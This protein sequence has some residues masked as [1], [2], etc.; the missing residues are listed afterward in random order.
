MTLKNMNRNN[1]MM[2]MASVE[3]NDLPSNRSSFRRNLTNPS[4]ASLAPTESDS[5]S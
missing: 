4:L 5:S 3:L 1:S 2:D